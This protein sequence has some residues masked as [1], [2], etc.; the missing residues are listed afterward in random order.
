MNRC[1]TDRLFSGSGTMAQDLTIKD[2]F[3]YTISTIALGSEADVFLGD[4]AFALRRI[5]R[6]GSMHTCS[7][8]R[9]FR[10]LM[11]NFIF[12]L[13]CHYSR[14]ISDSAAGQFATCV[15]LTFAVCAAEMERKISR[16][17]MNWQTMERLQLISNNERMWKTHTSH[18]QSK[19]PIFKT[20]PTLPR[21]KISDFSF[22][23][24]QIHIP[25]NDWPFSADQ[26]F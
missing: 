26:W 7:T 8:F 6:R 13:S 1:A 17:M 12:A 24:H 14:T 4:L 16:A 15:W 20:S 9:G 22:H 11:S 18:C 21:L 3:L 23:F 19:L 5:L 25:T 10:Y 2:N